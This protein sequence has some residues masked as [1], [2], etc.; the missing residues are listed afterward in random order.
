[1]AQ[2]CKHWLNTSAPVAA[3]LPRPVP[4]IFSCGL[5]RRF[6]P[7]LCRPL[8]SGSPRLDFHVALQIWTRVGP[9]IWL[10]VG[11]Q[12]WAHVAPQAWVHAALQPWARVGL[13]V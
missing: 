9:L 2:H 8:Y 7:P 1:S 13:Q 3:D 12:A 4:V 11:L 6:C 5:F 10:L